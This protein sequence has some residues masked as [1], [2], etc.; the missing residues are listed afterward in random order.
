MVAQKHTSL[1][2]PTH[3]YVLGLE[4]I[5][6]P[7]ELEKLLSYIPELKN[8]K[9][10][11]TSQ[12]VKPVR[13]KMTEVYGK[14]G[15]RG[16]AMCSGRAAFKHLLNLQGNQLGFESNS[17]RFLPTRLKLRKGLSLLAEWMENT[18]H[19]EIQ[20]ENSE[21]QWSFKATHCSECAELM[22]TESICDFTAGLLQ[23]FTAWAGGGKFHRIVETSCRANG[24]E[25]C[26]FMIDK[27]PID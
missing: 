27:N 24:D 19:D 12:H 13:Q 25:C 9:G 2:G 15:A 4:E 8:I 21:S 10:E 5:I 14:T 18:H 11:I 6:G 16:I 26:T 20:I 1:I 3:F 7:E 23:E 17:F 22:S